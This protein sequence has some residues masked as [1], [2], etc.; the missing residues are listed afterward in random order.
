MKAVTVQGLKIAYE[1]AGDGPP[2]VLLH[3][4][5]ADSRAWRPQITGLA[6]SFLVIA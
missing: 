1:P 4:F 3:R 6:R 2:L 5:L